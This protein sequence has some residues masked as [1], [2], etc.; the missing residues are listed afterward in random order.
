MSDAE[1]PAWVAGY[2]SRSRTRLLARLRVLR[3]YELEDDLLQAAFIAL[4]R[5]AREGITF[6]T[7]RAADAYVFTTCKN[8]YIS[9][10]RSPEWRTKPETT[11]TLETHLG[12][13]PSA[14]DAYLDIAE[15]INNRRT[16]DE[17]LANLRTEHRYHLELWASGEFKLPEIATLIGKSP[18]AEKVQRHRLLSRLRGTVERV[19]EAGK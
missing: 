13:A 5:K 16:A 19:K 7:D 14:E 2:Y 18:G 6:E 11:E 9:L 4:I 15:M 17:L 10:M 8:L 1:T 12:V 3:A